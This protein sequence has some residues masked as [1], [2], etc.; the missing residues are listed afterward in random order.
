[1]LNGVVTD[2]PMMG[3]QVQLRAQANADI[4]CSQ[5]TMTIIPMESK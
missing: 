3:D 5:G 1:V 4:S 2:G